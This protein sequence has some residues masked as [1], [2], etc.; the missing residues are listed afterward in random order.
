MFCV[1]SFPVGSLQAII[2]LN[3]VIVKHSSLLL[4]IF[5]HP[6]ALFYTS[7]YYLA[8]G[9]F[10]DSDIYI[11]ISIVYYRLGLLYYLTLLHLIVMIN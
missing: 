4:K 2:C 8:G 7:V 9:I 5:H 1:H 6:H 10:D 11:D 3:L